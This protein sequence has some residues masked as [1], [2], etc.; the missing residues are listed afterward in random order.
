MTFKNSSPM[1]K[2]ITKIV[3]TTINDAENLNLVMPMYNLIQYSSSYPET[4]GSLSFYSKDEAP[5]FNSDIANTDNFRSFKCKAKLL[6]NA[7]AYS[8]CS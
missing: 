4:R 8:K 6:E 5:D 3:Q 2:C 1:T 7:S